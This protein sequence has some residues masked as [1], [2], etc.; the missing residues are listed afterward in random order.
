MKVLQGLNRCWTEST[1]C[2]YCCHL[3]CNKTMWRHGAGRCTTQSHWRYESVQPRQPWLDYKWLYNFSTGRLATCRVW[4]QS[5]KQ[6]SM[7]KRWLW[8]TLLKLQIKLRIANER[9][10]RSHPEIKQMLQEFTK[11]WV[12]GSLSRQGQFFWSI[13]KISKRLL[14]VSASDCIWFLFFCSV[15][16]RC[17]H[18]HVDFFTDPAL[19]SKLNL[20]WLLSPWFWIF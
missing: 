12:C 2:P 16:A 6:H 9:Y 17:F 3:F 8:K 11:Y 1:S 18:L 7:V 4:L 19:A 20:S 13:L 15:F 10:L 14:E 5:S